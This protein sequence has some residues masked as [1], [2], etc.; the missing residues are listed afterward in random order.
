LVVSIEIDPLTYAYAQGNLARAGYHDIVLVQGDGGQGYA[1]LSPYDRIAVTAACAEIPAPLIEQLRMGGKLIAPL[2]ERGVQILTL[3][4]KN[5]A[6]IE[7]RRIC[8]VLYV[9]LRGAASPSTES[10]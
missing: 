6:G 8:E 3:I 5:A 9:P 7:R 10:S 2:L 1:P 4:E